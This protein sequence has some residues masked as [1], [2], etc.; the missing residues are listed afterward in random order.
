MSLNEILWIERGD[1]AARAHRACLLGRR[2][3]AATI[4]LLDG[5]G[6]RD[7]PAAEIVPAAPLT[8]AEEREYQRL[9][10]ELAGTHGE[11]RKLRR[12]NGLR[13]RSLVY[14]AGGAR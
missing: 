1:G 12:F 6:R 5:G 14:P 2:R 10:A 13:L 7:V 4:A 8:A 11:A 9:D 3:A